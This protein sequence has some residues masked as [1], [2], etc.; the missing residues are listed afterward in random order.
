MAAAVESL[1]RVVVG[2][3]VRACRGFSGHVSIVPIGG[4]DKPERREKRRIGE[5]RREEETRGSRGEKRRGEEGGTGK[6]GERRGD[7]RRGE[8]KIED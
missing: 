5:E 6:R 8:Q 4:E 1:R 7:K 3:Y 2:I